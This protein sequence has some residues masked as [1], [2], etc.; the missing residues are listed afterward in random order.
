MRSMISA[1][2]ATVRYLIDSK[3]STLLLVLRSLSSRKPG[4]VGHL[5]VE[6]QFRIAVP[7]NSSKNTFVHAAAGIDQRG[8]ND[9]KRAMSVHLQNEDGAESTNTS[10]AFI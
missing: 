6:D 9:G 7:L 4:R 2:A 10:R 8:R 1:A 5:A 3:N